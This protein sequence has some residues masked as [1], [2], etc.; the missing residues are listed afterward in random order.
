MTYA[1]SI[2]P[3]EQVRSEIEVDCA[4]RA[5]AVGNSRSGLMGSTGEASLRHEEPKDPFPI[6]AELSP[7]VFA[8]C[9]SVRLRT[10]AT[11]YVLSGAGE[12][13]QSSH[14]DPSGSGKAPLDPFRD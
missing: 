1:P 9:G 5:G 3:A 4:A 6:S 11:V 7:C 14:P 8:S 2:T 13:P 12:I 10:T